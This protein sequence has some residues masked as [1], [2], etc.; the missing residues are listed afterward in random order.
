MS[1]S[2]RIAVIPGDG[3]G[4]EVTAEAV[5]VLAAA[6]QLTGI[7]IEFSELDWG[8][9]KY[10]REGISVPPDG[11]RMLEENFDAILLGAMGDPRVLGNQHAVDILLG[12]RFQLDLYANVRPVKL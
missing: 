7:P 4:R 12:M 10:L 9:D 2:K 3:I 6:A 5:A 8:A 11:F 1:N